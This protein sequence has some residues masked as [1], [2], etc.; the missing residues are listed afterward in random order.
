MRTGPLFIA[1]PSPTSYARTRIRYEKTLLRRAPIL[2]LHHL[3]T[4]L[5]RCATYCRAAYRRVSQDGRLGHD[6]QRARRSSRTWHPLG[7]NTGITRGGN[8]IPPRE[9]DETVRRR[10][11]LL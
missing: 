9:R 1:V 3:P 5:V 4:C 7:R 11:D 2:V 10:G 6:D 8:R